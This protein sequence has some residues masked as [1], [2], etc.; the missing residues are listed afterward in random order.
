MK[1]T[2]S[3]LELNTGSH[4]GLFLFCLGT[5]FDMF[6]LK[7]NSL[8]VFLR[9]CSEIAVKYGILKITAIAWNLGGSSFHSTHFCHFKK[10]FIKDSV[11]FL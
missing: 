3:N 6:S 2:T 8:I 9:N 5:L 11:D 7:I 1:K 10:C 4:S